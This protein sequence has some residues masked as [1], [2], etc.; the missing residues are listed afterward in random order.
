MGRIE[1]KSSRVA[2]YWFYY[3]LGGRWVGVGIPQI[4][5]RI[6]W[7]YKG[8][9]AKTPIWGPFECNYSRESPFGSGKCLKL[10]GNE[11]VMNILFGLW[12]IWPIGVSHITKIGCTRHISFSF[13]ASNS[14]WLSKI[15]NIKTCTQNQN[16]QWFN[17]Y[18]VFDTILHVQKLQR[19]H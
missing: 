13:C 6:T 17:G 2:K 10:K 19:W 7:Y 11:E 5:K 4:L 12:C 16:K 8:L 3:F 14:D 15:L 18:F 1:S 9:S